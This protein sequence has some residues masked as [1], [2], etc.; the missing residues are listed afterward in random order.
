MQAVTTLGTGRVTA[1]F[2]VL[3][4]LVLA[5]KGRR[6]SA[7]VMLTVV[8]AGTSV[9]V[10]AIK[11]LTT[12]TRPDVA[13]L[14]TAAPGYAFPS[15]HSAQAT[16]AYGAIA[17]LLT[18]RL[19]RWGQRVTVWAIAVLVITLVGFSRLYLGAHWLTDV[20][21][22]FTLG[23]AWTAL[24]ITTFGILT[25]RPV[26]RMNATTAGPPTQAAPAPHAR[27]NRPGRRFAAGR[28]SPTGRRGS[29]TDSGCRIGNRAA[30]PAS[31]PCG[32]LAWKVGY[33][34]WGFARLHVTHEA[35][36]G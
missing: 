10:D 19:R 22:G 12:A 14:L 26:Q 15:G 13:D 34:S 24:T 6:W 4:V 35:L 21:G 8:A 11:L 20:L 36:H 9:L 5:R 16:A 17:Y 7:A 23:A 31:A 33:T 29:G 1:V 30:R 2:L 18:G 32:P 3:A 28:G 25:R 27:R